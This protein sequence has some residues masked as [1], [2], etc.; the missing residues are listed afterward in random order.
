MD[1]VKGRRE[2]KSFAVGLSMSVAVTVLPETFIL[3]FMFWVRSEEAL[4]VITVNTRPTASLSEAK[5]S[6][7]A[8]KLEKRDRAICHPNSKLYSPAITFDFGNLPR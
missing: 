8:A 6:L 2:A 4:G 1:R 5:C 7:S 3:I